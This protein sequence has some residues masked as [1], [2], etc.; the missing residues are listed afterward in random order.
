MPSMDLNNTTKIYLGSTECTRLYLGGSL[1]WEKAVVVSDHIK[2]VRGTVVMAASSASVT[3]T[4]GVDYTLE[5]GIASTAWFVRVVNSKHTG[6]GNTSGGGSRSPNQMTVSTSY[7]GNNV[8]F[9]RALTASTDNRITYEIWQYVGPS[10]GAN[11][12]IVRQKTDVT[13]AGGTKT[14]SLAVPGTVS[15]S[16]NVVPFITSQRSAATGSSQH[17]FHATVTLNGSN[18]DVER[19]HTTAQAIYS[20]SLVEFTGSNWSIQAVTFDEDGGG[21]RV[22]QVTIPTTLNS[23]SEAFIH[24]TFR[25]DNTGN[26]GLNDVSRRIR[27][28]STTELEFSSQADDGASKQH[29]TYIIENPEI[30][31]ARYTGTMAGSG[32]EENFNITVTDVGD[33]SKVG[34]TV[35]NDST[36]SGTAFPRGYVDARLTSGTNV[37]LTQSDNG[38]T[39]EYAI[40]IIIFP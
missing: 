7:S 6:M 15:N 35:S 24:D 4:D 3:I 29:C 25:Y 1:A 9:T 10:G 16:T 18:F 19:G 22:G 17:D 23:A 33:L 20:L 28:L 36:G 2:V 40:E 37:L 12:F 34:L 8:T 26:H 21:S 30:A 32:E 13:L 38:Q 11:E 27:I 39:S 5:S 31:V 14:G